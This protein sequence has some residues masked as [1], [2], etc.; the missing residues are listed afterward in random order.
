MCHFNASL[1]ICSLNLMSAL[2]SSTLPI[3]YRES[4]SEVLF[5]P[6]CCLCT[7]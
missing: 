4:I 1:H 5:V 3:T 7:Q 2:I 6:S